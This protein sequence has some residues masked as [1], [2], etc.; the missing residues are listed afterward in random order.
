MQIRR[1]RRKPFKRDKKR[2]RVNQ[3]IRI[4]EVQL[5]D[6]DGNFL[7]VVSTHEAQKRAHESGLDLVEVDPSKRPSI[8]K[9]TDYGQMKYEREKKERKAKTAQKKTEIKSIR[10][11]FRIKG[12]DLE[13]RKKQA[14]KFLEAGNKVKLDTILKGREKAHRGLAEENLRKFVKEMGEDIETISPISRQGG[15][16]SITIGRKS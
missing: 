3:F 5:I 11:S 8:A 12:H 7:G 1:R 2:L 13:T 15:T 6:E 10:L 4:P 16:I 14:L 9:I